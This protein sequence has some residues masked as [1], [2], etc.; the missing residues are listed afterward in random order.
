MNAE[1]S[2]PYVCDLIQA[3]QSDDFAVIYHNCGD[4][5][6]LMAPDIYQLGAMGYHFGDAISMTDVLPGAPADA[7]IMGNVSPSVQFCNGTPASITEA[8]HAVIEACCQYPNY[9][10]SSGCDIPPISPWENIEA[11]FAAAESFYC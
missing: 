11:F 7:L 5:V 4:N 9:L 1:F 2:R 8:T 10:I 3:V 6:A